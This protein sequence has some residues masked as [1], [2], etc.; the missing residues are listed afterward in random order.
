MADS[1]EELAFNEALISR[2]KQWREEKGWTAEQMAIA[3]GIPAARYRKY[4]SRTPLP[5]YLFQRFCLITETDLEN[6]LFGKPRPRA[7]PPRFAASKRA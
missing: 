3:L 5:A 4:E 7:N 2:V 6:L 1:N